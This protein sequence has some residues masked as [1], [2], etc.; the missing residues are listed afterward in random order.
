MCKDFKGMSLMDIQVLANEQLEKKELE[1]KIAQE[2]QKE[3]QPSYCIKQL[4]SENN[5]NDALKKLEENNID[6]EAFWGL[7]NAQ[8]KEQLGIEAYGE[9][10]H[11][12]NLMT[13]IKSKHQK[14]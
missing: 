7:D 5:L 12:E 8:I 10:K 9:R 4:L 6:L 3:L 14:S 1:M 13:E 11:L 2:K